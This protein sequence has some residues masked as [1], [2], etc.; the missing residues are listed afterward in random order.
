MSSDGFSF[1]VLVRR[2]PD[3]ISLFCKFFEFCDDFFLFRCDFV[4]RLE[5]FFEVNTNSFLWQIDDMTIGC[6]D[7]IVGSEEFFDG[8]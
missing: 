1:T 8:F 2:D 7:L 3:F 6:F 4:G 5:V